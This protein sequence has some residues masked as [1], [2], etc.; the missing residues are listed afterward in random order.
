MHVRRVNVQEAIGHILMHNV[1]DAT[2]RRVARKGVQVTPE[3][4]A[5]LR[6]AGVADVMVAVLAPDD[7]HE[8]E[9][10]RR[11]ADALVTPELFITWGVGGRA[12]LHSEVL[13]VVYVDAARLQAFNL[14]EGLTLATVPPY[15]VVR[16]EE[17]RGLV[18]TLK[19]IPFAV[20]RATLEEG[21]RLARQRPGIVEVRPLR[22]A[23]AAL[24]LTGHPSALP[25]LRGQF[26]PPTRRRLERL[27]S[28]LTSVEL[29]PQEEEAIAE[30]AATLLANHDLLII[31]G[32]TSVMDREDIT[33]RALRSIGATVTVH[34]APVDPGN[35]LALAYL[36]TKPI[37]CAPGCAR[38]LARNVVD[39]VLPRLLVG[40]YLTQ[41]EIAA[42]GLGGLL[43]ASPEV[44][45]ARNS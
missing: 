25:R 33:L 45:A 5:R 3:V 1:V 4:A 43:H 23:R 16:P 41:Q 15:T 28:L 7:V 26:E 27:G 2:G 13:G 24:M 22:S 12:N 42:L 19:V 11:L 20:S 38:S 37:L 39:L 30:A 17:H 35:L 10:A 44:D 8:D 34:G 6:A 14:L 32:Q 36:D 21:L 29:V 40:E 18:A 9:A 31:S